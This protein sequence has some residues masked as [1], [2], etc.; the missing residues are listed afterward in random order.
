MSQGRIIIYDDDS[1]NVDLLIKGLIIL[2]VFIERHINLRCYKDFYRNSLIL[3]FNG[4]RR[5]LCNIMIKSMDFEV[6][7][8]F[9]SQL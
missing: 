2:N 1:V 4:I 6:R 3:V 5:K 7:P 8:T 9:K